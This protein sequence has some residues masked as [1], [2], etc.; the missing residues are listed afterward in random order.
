VEAQE[1]QSPIPEIL[2]NKMSIGDKKLIKPKEIDNNILNS[3]NN[4]NKK[5]GLNEIDDRNNDEII[6]KK[7]DNIT[8]KE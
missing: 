1:V 3:M 7:I 6:K 4:T 8:I 5:Y 2:T